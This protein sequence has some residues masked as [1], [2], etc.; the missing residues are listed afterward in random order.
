MATS[1]ECHS[2]LLTCHFSSSQT[3]RQSVRRWGHRRLR[4]ST[5]SFFGSHCPS[6]THHFPILPWHTHGVAN[7]QDHYSWSEFWALL[8]YQALPEAGFQQ[9]LRSSA[10]PSCSRTREEY[11]DIY[12]VNPS[13]CHQQSDECSRSLG[14]RVSLVG[15]LMSVLT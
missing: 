10:V 5:R 14:R 7:L 1:T 4:S 11:T 9:I 15:Y 8:E 2:Q 6:H 13:E 3:I 12:L